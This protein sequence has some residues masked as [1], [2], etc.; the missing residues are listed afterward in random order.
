MAPRTLVA[1]ATHLLARGYL[2]VSTDRKNDAGEPTNALFALTQALRRALGMKAP[3]HAVAVL[4]AAFDAAGAPPLLARQLA[5]LPE[6]LA[7]HGLAVV[8]TPRAADVVASYTQAA[9][10]AGHDVVVVGSDKR[11]AQLVGERVWWYDAYKDVRYTPE[12]VRKRF[13]VG[14]GEVAG[15]LAL[16]GDD[17]T[18]PGV[19]GIGKKGATD[20]VKAF[21]SIDEA[22]AQADAAAGRTGK[23]LRASLDDAVREVA[24]ARLDRALP[25]P[26]PLHELGYRP[27]TPEAV[28]RFYGELGFNELLASDASAPA[29]DVLVCATA[30]EARAALASLGSAP[31]ALA[32]LTEDPSPVRGRLV[33]LALARGDGRS[34]Y[35]PFAGLGPCLESPAVLADWLGDASRPKVG[36]DVKAAIVALARHGVAVA[37]VA[38]DSA[39]ASH[40]A[41]PSNWAPHDLPIVAKQRLRRALAED[42]AVR[43]VGRARKSWAAL[44]VDRAAPFAAERADAAAALWRSFEPTAPRALLAEYLELSDTLVRMELHGLACDE[45]DLLQ[46]GDD[47]SAIGAALE[48]EIHA[49]A[50]KRFNLGSTKQLGEVLYQD[51]GLPIVKRSKTGWSTA[52]E[53]LERIEHAHPIVAKVMRWRELERLKDSWV[54]AL[55]GAID[56]DGRV[57]STFHPARSFS[58][59]LVNSQPDLGRVPGRTPEMARIRRAFRAPPGKKL[60]SVDYNQLGLYVLAHLSR[61]PALVEPLRRRDDL[62]RL[63]AA[64]VLELAPEAVGDDERQRGK[65]VNFATFAGQGA[66]ALALQLGLSAPEAKRLIERFDRHYAAVRAFQDEQLR[67][68]EKRGYVETLAGRRWPIGGLGALDPQ[69]RSYAERLARRA[70]HEGSVADVSRRGLLRADQ[71]LRAAGLRAVPLL[72][73]HDEVLFE[74]PDDELVAAAEV[75]AAAMRGAFELEVP[76]RVGCEAGPSWAELEPLP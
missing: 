19:T 1:H 34:C 37:G 31:V 65:L 42:D 7:E 25:L 27:P 76:L 72:Q 54:T 64:A 23:M 40:L 13:E 58:G 52:T 38:G 3:D 63:T 26:L 73:V 75:T 22:I 17:D 16:V 32:V 6:A 12:L 66:S 41:E 21:G 51:L 8:S 60:L 28:N 20:L 62:H 43:G 53:A 33:G 18:L 47:F 50:G 24:R 49:L 9:L 15:W 55:R 67:L 68:V 45:A 71:A 48:A 14:P 70:T 56:A 61:D 2:V 39:C 35:F 46:V 44:P 69:L 57:R 59:R 74:V 29:V 11:L 36:H 30:D 4:D 5:R 10:E